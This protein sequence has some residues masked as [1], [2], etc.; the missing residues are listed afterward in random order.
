MK[1][2]EE[3]IAVMQAYLDG[4]K[5]RYQ[6]KHEG[7]FAV[8]QKPTELIWDW[9]DC[10]YEVAIDEPFNLEEFKAGRKAYTRDGKIATFIGICD[11]CSEE[12]KLIVHIE[13]YTECIT[14]CLNGNYTK[15]GTGRKTDL[16]SMV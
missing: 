4:K 5:I 13:G 15:N 8:C 6:F 7:I 3:K 14:H 10:D 16:I 1:T 9:S 11:E 12:F 2:T